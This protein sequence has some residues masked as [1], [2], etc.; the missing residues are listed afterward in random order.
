MLSVDGLR[1]D[2]FIGRPLGLW[3]GK[4]NEWGRGMSSF[5]S[6]YLQKFL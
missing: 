4:E 1:A 3:P 6:L 2:E 5:S